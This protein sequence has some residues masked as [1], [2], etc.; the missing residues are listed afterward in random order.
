MAFLNS[1]YMFWLVCCV[2]NCCSAMQGDRWS[3]A[4]CGM[5]VGV[6]VGAGVGCRTFKTCLSMPGVLC[7]MMRM[8][9]HV[10]VEMA[11]RVVWSTEVGVW[12]PDG[13]H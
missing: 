13:G 1:R 6:T 2:S 7:C 5:L 11:S 12:C 8:C 3:G 9:V 10:M 4:G